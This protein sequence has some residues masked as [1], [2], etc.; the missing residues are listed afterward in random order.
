MARDCYALF[1]STYL[2]AIA[3]GLATAVATAAAQS[4]M[5]DCLKQHSVVTP[6]VQP[7]IVSGDNLSPRGPIDGGV[8]RSV[9]LGQQQK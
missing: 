9:L 3:D 4:S 7:T 2:Q 8:D 6:T 5:D 1:K